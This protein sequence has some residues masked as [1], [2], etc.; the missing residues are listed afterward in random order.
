M[1]YR[2]YQNS[3]SNVKF[4]LARR[5]YGG[6]QKSNGSTT[7]DASKETLICGNPFAR[8][9]DGDG[10]RR[11]LL[12]V[13]RQLV[14]VVF[15]AESGCWWWCVRLVVGKKKSKEGEH[16]GRRRK[17]MIPVVRFRDGGGFR[18]YNRLWWMVVVR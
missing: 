16:S 11:T 2:S 8:L 15:V 12:V 17:K 1:C 10:R 14:A 13:F 9:A 4:L 18:G 5:R 6:V 3:D 7:A